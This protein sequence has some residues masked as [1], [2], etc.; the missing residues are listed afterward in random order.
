MQVREFIGLF[1]GGLIGLAF[2]ASAVS[3]NNNTVAVAQSLTDGF[4][5][6]IKAATFQ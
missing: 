2:F 1:I 5:T 6:D 4:A 3:K